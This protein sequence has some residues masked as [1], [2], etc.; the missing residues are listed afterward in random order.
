VRFQ[1]IKGHAGHEG[2]EG[3]DALA[4]RGAQMPEEEERNWQELEMNIPRRRKANE[5]VYISD[6]ELEVG[7]VVR[8]LLLTVLIRV[9]EYTGIHGGP[10]R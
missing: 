9:D 3:A 2:N 5:V 4:G 1:Y 7:R 10:C 6:E 8:Y